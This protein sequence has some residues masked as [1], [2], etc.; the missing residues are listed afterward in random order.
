MV[1]VSGAATLGYLDH[2][3]TNSIDLHDPWS[4]LPTCAAGSNRVAEPASNLWGLS[5]RSTKNVTI[6]LTAQSGAKD[7]GTMP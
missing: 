3:I 2:T 5:D 6:Q 7:S 1:K 4:R